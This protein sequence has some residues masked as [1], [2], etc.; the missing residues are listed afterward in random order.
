M[1]VIFAATGIPGM[2]ES[3]QV[4]QQVVCSWLTQQGSSQV[5]SG[6]KEAVITEICF[7]LWRT[8]QVHANH[9]VVQCSPLR[10]MPITE[11][12]CSDHQ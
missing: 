4:L 3:T 11:A 7:A 9:R 6:S 12:E 8:P 2:S 10:A 5:R 1:C